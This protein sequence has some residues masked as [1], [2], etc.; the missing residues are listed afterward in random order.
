MSTLCPLSS[1]LP[2]LSSALCKH[3]FV[4][5]KFG[6]FTSFSQGVEKTK[7]TEKKNGNKFGVRVMH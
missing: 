1:T 6:R 4:G 7:P 5:F 2:P 3:C